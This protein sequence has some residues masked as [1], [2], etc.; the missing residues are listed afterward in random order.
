MKS[1]QR[2]S[3]D[4]PS[5]A[6]ATEDHT[7]VERS[8]ARSAYRN[9]DLPPPC[10]DLRWTKTFLPTIFLWAGGQPNIWVIND[11]SLTLAIQATFKVVY[12]EVEHTPT[13]HGSVFGVVRAL[14]LP[15]SCCSLY[16]HIVDKSASLRMA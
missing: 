11:E 13:I 14:S 15:F 1:E 16:V 3:H 8:K 4:T 5:T 2:D 9:T 12:P 7:W 10:Q 6:K